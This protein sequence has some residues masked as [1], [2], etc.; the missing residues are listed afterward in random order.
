MYNILG[1]ILICVLTNDKTVDS[2]N[3]RN[4]GITSMYCT[5]HSTTSMGIVKFQG[6]GILAY[7]PEKLRLVNDGALLRTRTL[8]VGLTPQQV[9]YWTSRIKP[10]ICNY[11]EPKDL[12]RTKLLNPD[13]LLNVLCL[14][15]IPTDDIKQYDYNGYLVIEKSDVKPDN[16]PIIHSYMIDVK[17]QR[18]VQYTVFDKHQRRLLQA[19]IRSYYTNDIPENILLNWYEKGI[20]INWT[21]KNPRLNVKIPVNM[22]NMPK[23]PFM[24]AL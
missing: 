6:N 16:T 14:G 10:P 17:Y 5:T 18:V 11:G 20:S 21:L 7:E 8:D 1:I 13:V 3:V 2:I 23:Y 24:K 19:D 4:A 9:W 22:W 15:Q 12:S